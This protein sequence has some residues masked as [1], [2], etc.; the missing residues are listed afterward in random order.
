[1][2]LNTRV[3]RRFLMIFLAIG[4]LPLA[5]VGALVIRT[6]ESTVRQQT[7]ATLR[8]ASDGAEAQLREFLGHLEHETLMLADEEALS[9]ALGSFAPDTARLAHPEALKILAAPQKHIPEAQEIFL[10]DPDGRV[11]AA[12][13]AHRVGQNQSQSSYFLRGKK[14]FY[15]G[16]LF[17]DPL[18]GQVTWIL[19]APIEDRV[20]Q[21]LLGVLACRIDPETLSA[22]TTGR[23][24]LAEG[25]DTQSFRIGD[26]GETYIVNRDQ[27][28][29]TES[30]YVSNA[31]LTVKVDTLPVRA[32]FDRGQDITADY[33]D[34]R[35]IQVSGASAVLRAPGWV[36]LTEI[37]F[38]QAF[39]SVHYFRRVLIAVLLGLAFIVALLAWSST[40]RIIRPIQL[41]H[42]SD[43]GLAIGDQK[44]SVISEVGLPHD[45]LGELVHKRNSRVRRI[46]AYQE[47]LEQRT[48]RLKDALAELEHMSY[49]IVHDMRAPLRAMRSVAE[50]LTDEEEECSG[51]VRRKFLQRIITAADRMDQLIT[52]A[53]S[54]S[55][56]VRRELALSPV[57]VEKLLKEMVV[58]YPAFQEAGASI[59]VKE[60][61][62]LVLGNAAALTQCFSN[63]LAN[64]VKFVKPGEKARVQVWAEVR[65]GRPRP[66]GEEAATRDGESRGTSGEYVRIWVEDNGTGISESMLPRVFDMFSHGL[67]PQAG[68]GIGLALVRKVVDR[69]GG[70]VGVESEVGKGSRFW[71]EFKPARGEQPS[72][73]QTAANRSDQ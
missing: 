15:C 28:I 10:L 71:V 24:I 63:L 64:A 69:M 23:R 49:S 1:M 36:L 41:L 31:V 47:E 58:T 56:A 55:Q 73:Q 50:L 33:R 45:E 61:I 39:A 27:F 48:A 57:N 12:T 51:E 35:G 18:N 7:S 29:I 68:T 59:T 43:R 62:P 52:D 8:A 32:A 44:A 20:D 53:L 70:H 67:S 26:T 34:Y 30:R 14:A 54:Y 17:R 5:I 16:D 60:G 65:I 37:D 42:E 46:L 40:R 38:S 9:Q 66:E 6:G 11:V 3:G 19:A 4:L 13:D 72:G 22:L 21:R 25:A 2:F